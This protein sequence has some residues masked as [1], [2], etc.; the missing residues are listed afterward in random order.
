MASTE[1]KSDLITDT[2]FGADG[3]TPMTP[4]AK[5]AQRVMD[6][7]GSEKEIL[8]AMHNGSVATL[9][10]AGPSLPELAGYYADLGD[11][12]LEL[13]RIVRVLT[14]AAPADVETISAT[15][16]GI[17]T[18]GMKA[19]GYYEHPFEDA[20]RLKNQKCRLIG[21]KFE[22]PIVTLKVITPKPAPK[23]DVQ[24]TIGV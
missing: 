20:P 11:R 9:M 18:Q 10:M 17:S 4:E 8:D 23:L 6:A 3:K 14:P 19:T 24:E 21:R 12:V 1:K 5:E 16:V 13:E 22:S 7:G 15:M 2:H